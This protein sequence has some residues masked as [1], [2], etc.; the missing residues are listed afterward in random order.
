[1]VAAISLASM[2]SGTALACYAPKAPG[3][4]EQLE[5]CAGVLLIAGLS[6]IGSGLRLY[7]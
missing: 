1:M 6:L 2:L 7:C 5:W 4:T 3:R